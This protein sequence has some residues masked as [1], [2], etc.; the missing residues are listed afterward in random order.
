MFFKSTISLKI[1]LK[2][3]RL[4][5]KNIQIKEQINDVITVS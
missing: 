2:I 3:F 5:N 1:I 4:M